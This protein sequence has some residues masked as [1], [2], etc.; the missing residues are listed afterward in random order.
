[1]THVYGTQ[2]AGHEVPAPKRTRRGKPLPRYDRRQARR[3]IVAALAELGRI[4]VT[5]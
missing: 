3:E 1:M 5:A 2:D 4:E